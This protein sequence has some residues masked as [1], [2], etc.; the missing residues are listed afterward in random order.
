MIARNLENAIRCLE[1][2]G[3]TSKRSEKMDLL[4]SAADNPI[5]KEIFRRAYDWQTT[6]G[7]TVTPPD[8][9]KM[10]S[11]FGE[12][13]DL[14]EE[15]AVFLLLLEELEKRKLTGSAAVTTIERFLRAVGPE[16][17]IWYSRVINKDLKIGVNVATY[18]E[19]WPDLKSKFGV[20]LAEKFDSTVELRYPLAVEPKY[21][22]LR[23]TMVF[24]DSSGVAKTRGDKQ[25]NDV[26]AGILGELGSLVSNGAIDG[27]IYA[28]WEKT[29]PLSTFGGKR[30]KSPWGKTSAMLK[31]GTTRQGFDE[32]RI[33]DQMWQEI[34]RDLK[35]WAFDYIGLEVFNPSIAVDKTP[36]KDRRHKL[37]KLVDALGEDSSVQIMPQRVVNCRGE[38]DDAHTHFLTEG[39]EGSMIKMLDAPYFP[40]RTAV[41]LKRKELEFLDGV[42][43]E[44]LPGKELGQNANRAGSYRVRLPNGLETKC[45]IRGN[46]NRQDHWDRRDE[47]VG[48][49]IEMVGQKDAKAVTDKARFAVFI[50][51]RDDLPKEAV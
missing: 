12:S 37:K 16:R 47:L 26:L 44:V 51:L 9:P 7:L 8:V 20:S 32:T 17:G 39:H 5:L 13:Y 46:N 43:L 33:S 36:F 48:T 28:D 10:A 50:R 34:H 30:Y 15:W 31:T 41:M 24:K 22:G 1:N 21:D 35:F 45:N 18:G 49:R 23:I 40:S 2:L 6:Y 29:G 4:R 3:D 25:Y 38:L 27:E 14:E 42:I 11:T 19:V